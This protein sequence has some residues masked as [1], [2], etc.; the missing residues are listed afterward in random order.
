MEAYAG[1]QYVGIDLHRRRTVIVRTTASGEVLEAVRIVNV[2]LPQ[3]GVSF[4]PALTDGLVGASGW[5]FSEV[6]GRSGGADAG[7]SAGCR[8]RGDL[9]ERGHDCCGPWP[10]RW[11]SQPPPASTC[12]QSGGHV[13]APVAQRLGLGLGQLWC[14]RQLPQ[15]G[16]EVGADRGQL[17]RA[18]LIAKPRNGNRPRRESFAWRIRSSTRAWAR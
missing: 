11:D 13:Q 16:D 15:P 10:V 1:K 5:R 14:Q 4:G 9:G 17:G 18:V 6:L 12:G 2:N 8:D 7:R 3:G